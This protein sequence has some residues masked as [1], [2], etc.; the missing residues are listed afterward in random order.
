[1]SF[2]AVDH[3][4]SPKYRPAAFPGHGILRLTGGSP[5][6]VLTDFLH[7]ALFIGTYYCGLVDS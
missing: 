5:L 7:S 6:D 4:G 3:R 2:D 1:M